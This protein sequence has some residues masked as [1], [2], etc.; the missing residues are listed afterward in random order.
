MTESTILEKIIKSATRFKE[1]ENASQVS[2]FADDPV[3]QISEP[4]IPTV[5]AVANYGAS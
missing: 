3:A 5:R 1:N 4:E 2:L